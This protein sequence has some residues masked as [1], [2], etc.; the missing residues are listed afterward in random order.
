M[1]FSV[2]NLSISFGG[3]KAVNELTF[4]INKD[5]IV[6]LIGPNGAGKTTAFNLICGFLKPET[7]IIYFEGENITRLAPNKIA[8]KGITRTFQK[9][10]IFPNATVLECVMMGS[11]RNV[12]EAFVDIIFKTQSFQ[13]SEKKIKEKA[14]AILEF[15]RLK[16]RRNVYGKNLS[17]G[18]QRLLEIAIGLAVEPELLLLDEPVT[19]MNPS[20]SEHVMSIVSEIRTKGITILLVEHNMD[21]VM[22]ISDR[23]VVLDHGRKIS[24][25]LP[26]QI[27]EDEKVLEAYLGKGFFDA[28][29]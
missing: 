9:T 5:E 28:E 24:E 1:Y 26:N 27:Q 7:G 2:E 16:D 11:Y 19:G 4:H 12:K 25:G 23:I 8:K 18:E 6:S 17:Y 3:L 10:N 15:I 22:N 14:E 29:G 13:Q 20:E 21:A